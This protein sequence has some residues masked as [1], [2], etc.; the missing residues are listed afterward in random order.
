MNIYEHVEYSA[1]YSK[2]NH[3]TQH[4]LLDVSARCTPGCLMC[5]I[6]TLRCHSH[7][8]MRSIWAKS[9]KGAFQYFVHP[10]ETT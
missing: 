6:D 5:C 3:S 8:P 4:S 1:T 10:G 9:F 7:F 2:C